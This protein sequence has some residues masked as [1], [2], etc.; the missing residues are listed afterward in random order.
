MSDDGHRPH[1]FPQS[2]LDSGA[3][4][5]AWKCAACGEWV[6]EYGIADRSECPIDWRSAP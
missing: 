1:R 5:I 3:E 6:R 2:A 4:I